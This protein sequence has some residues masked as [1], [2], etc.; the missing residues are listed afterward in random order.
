MG[1]MDMKGIIA[2]A[3]AKGVMKGAKPG[4]GFAS[5]NDFTKGAEK[6]GLSIGGKPGKDGALGAIGL[7]VFFFERFFFFVERFFF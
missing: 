3:Q 6:G 1:P 7:F 5:F 2:E 4:Y